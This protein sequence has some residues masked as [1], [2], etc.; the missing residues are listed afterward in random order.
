M[1]L[2]NNDLQRFNIPYAESLAK[3]ER[4]VYFTNQLVKMMK[5][6]IPIRTQ[7]E[8]ADQTRV[9]ILDAAIGQFSINGLAGARTEQIAEEAGVNKALIYYYF[10]GKD[11]LY[12]A[13]LESVA[14]G[15]LADNMAVLEADASAGEKFVQSALNHFDKVHTNRGFQSLMQQEMVRL[16]RGEAN[17]LTQLVETVFRPLTLKMNEVIAEGITSGELIAVDP[18]QIR[19]AAM[20]ANVFYFLSAPMMK[21]IQ[22]TDPMSLDAIKHFRIAAMEYLGQTIFVE[23]DHGAEV[24]AK[25]L[26]ATPMPKDSGTRP[27]PFLQHHKVP[28]VRL[29]KTN[30]EPRS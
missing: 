24:A 29:T 5:R 6:T 8:R 9:R 11:A 20:G 18:A 26:K 13:A 4:T 28:K 23:R 3:K 25:V 12:K 10:A 15:V 22:G 2:T 14:Q 1:V 27:H 7:S 16:H 21:M 30:G 17:A 19:Y